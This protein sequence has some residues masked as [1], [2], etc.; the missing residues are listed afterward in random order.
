MSDGSATTC[1]WMKFLGWRSMSIWS[2]RVRSRTES[3]YY[4]G[5]LQ[6][7]D[8]QADNCSQLTV[9]IAAASH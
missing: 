8:R 4:A 5:S 9:I 2:A 7:Q 1:P 3:S 6:S